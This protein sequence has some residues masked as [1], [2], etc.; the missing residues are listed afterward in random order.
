VAKFVHVIAMQVH[1]ERQRRP[2]TCAQ[3]TTGIVVKTMNDARGIAEPLDRYGELL[4]CQIVGLYNAIHGLP[5]TSEHSRARL[6]RLFHE[7]DGLPT[8]GK[9]LVR[10]SYQW[11]Y[12][13]NHQ[14]I[15]R[16]TPGTSR[17]LYAAG[18]QDAPTMRWA[19][20]SR[21]VSLSDVSEHEPSDHDAGLSFVVSSIE[22]GVRRN[23]T[24]RYLTHLDIIKNA[25]SEA[26]EAASPLSIPMRELAHTFPSGKHVALKSVHVKPDA[27]FG[28]QYPPLDDPDF[29]FFAVEY[30]R[31]TEDV[32]PTGSLARASWLRKLLSY[33]AISANPKAI[34][35]TYLKIPELLV[36]C[37]FSDATRLA[38]V[39]DLVRRE[40]AH[41]N[42]FL[43]KTI[44][45]I[46]PLI[47]ACPMPQLF[48]EPWRTVNGMISIDK[49][50]G[51][52]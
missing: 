44:P 27:L 38:H 28:I 34:Y 37:I 10:P 3:K 25:S 33:S 24:L 40:A 46:D 49:C 23:V 22:I 43:F 14:T 41:P 12:G 30:D 42:Q 29:R 18:V 52:R 11:R 45:P 7:S 31:S 9:I 16:R 50:E 5:A 47:C 8:T 21:I 2:R 13:Y 20:K 6:G 39:M 26:Q 15:Y 36:L 51:R 19:N 17:F 35:Q 4:A 1:N 32:E 48:T